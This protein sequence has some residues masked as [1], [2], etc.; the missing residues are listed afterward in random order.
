MFFRL[1]FP[2]LQ[3]WQ[4]IFC[5][6]VSNMVKCWQNWRHF[7]SW[8]RQIGSWQFHGGRHLGE[9]LKWRRDAGANNRLI[10][11][12]TTGPAYES[13]ESCGWRRLFEL[14][15]R[16]YKRRSWWCCIAGVLWAA[17]LNMK[18]TICSGLIWK[19]ILS[20]SQ[21]SDFLQ[22]KLFEKTFCLLNDAPITCSLNGPIYLRFSVN[23]QNKGLYVFR[24]SASH[25]L[26][27]W[28]LL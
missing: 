22:K 7:W 18:L 17:K 21:Q 3:C 5:R 23:K 16:C 27:S 20:F 4:C 12:Y 2:K 28:N 13:W 6:I 14:L 26:S 15:F 9:L 24:W 19:I 1:N 10:S 25:D 11:T 8:N